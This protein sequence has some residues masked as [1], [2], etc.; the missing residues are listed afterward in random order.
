M[1]LEYDKKLKEEIDNFIA[2]IDVYEKSIIGIPNVL[3][4]LFEIRET[5][6]SILQTIPSY[7]LSFKNKDYFES[8]VKMMKSNAIL[9][10]YNLVESTIRISMFEYYTQ[11]NNQRLSFDQAIEPI[12]KLWI[13]NYLSQINGN[14]LNQEVFKMILNIMDKNYKVEIEK[15]SFHLSGNADVQQMK[16]IL[17]THGVDYDDDSFKDYGGALFTVKNKRNRL[18]H[19]NVS[20]EENGRD[21]SI[22]QIIELK[23]KTYDCLD[24]F[25]SLI[26]NECC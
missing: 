7:S 19:G 3:N 11:L 4:D 8:I 10:L 13:K 25:I 5:G 26:D 15:D 1:N 21:F 23:N 2:I 22:Q 18:A 12:K 14:E 20:F 24:Y 9:M 17:K 6:S 16:K